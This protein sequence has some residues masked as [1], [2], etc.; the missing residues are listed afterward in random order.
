MGR[1]PYPKDHPL[2]ARLLFI[3]KIEIKVSLL[4]LLNILQLAVCLLNCKVYFIDVYRV[5]SS[6]LVQ[7][8]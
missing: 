4:S 3:I 1:G 8:L 7:I 2:V 5:L 6:I